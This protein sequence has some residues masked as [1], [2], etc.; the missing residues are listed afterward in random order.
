MRNIV[1]QAESSLSGRHTFVRNKNDEDLQE[2]N[3]NKQQTCMKNGK[4]GKKWKELVK[5]VK[6]VTSMRKVHF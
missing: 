2:E 5:I 4:I 1:C 6:E 3:E